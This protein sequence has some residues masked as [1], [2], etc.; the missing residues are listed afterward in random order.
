LRALKYYRREGWVEVGR[1][2]DK[3]GG[4][5]V[6]ELDRAGETGENDPSFQ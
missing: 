2:A 3:D 4:H 1:G 5:Y 6:L